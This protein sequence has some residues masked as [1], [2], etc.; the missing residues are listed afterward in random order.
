MQVEAVRIVF[1][2]Y[3][4][5]HGLEQIG[6]GFGEGVTSVVGDMLPS[7]AYPER[8]QP[9]PPGWEKASDI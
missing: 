1:D 7:S 4:D 5:K 6:Q 3:A 9:L 8:L 2:E